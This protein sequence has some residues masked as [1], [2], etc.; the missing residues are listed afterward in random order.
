MYSNSSNPCFLPLQR[1]GGTTL[2]RPEA[3]RTHTGRTMWHCWPMELISLSSIEGDMESLFAED[4]N[5]S[6]DGWLVVVGQRNRVG[7]NSAAANDRSTV[8]LAASVN[9]LSNRVRPG[10]RSRSA[11]ILTRMCSNGSSTFDL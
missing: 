8:P 5:E 7:S 6:D 1:D 9:P 3:M 2:W 11:A 4:S 10:L